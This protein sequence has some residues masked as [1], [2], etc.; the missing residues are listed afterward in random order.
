M[1]LTISGELL[2]MQKCCCYDTKYKN[3]MYCIYIKIVIFEY[4]KSLLF[5]FSLTVF[6]VMKFLAIGSACIRN[7]YTTFSRILQLV[8]HIQTRSVEIFVSLPFSLAWRSCTHPGC[9][10]KSPIIIDIRNVIQ[11]DV[12]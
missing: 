3:T 1:L 7:N 5:Q 12:V 8:S 11:R 6:M 9:R 2:S 10:I 4:R